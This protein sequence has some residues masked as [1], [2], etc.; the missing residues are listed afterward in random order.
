MYRESIIVV[1]VV[2]VVVVVLQSTQYATYMMP[3]RYAWKA[4][5]G[6]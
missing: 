3:H 1:V 5:R 2:V 4:V 6:G